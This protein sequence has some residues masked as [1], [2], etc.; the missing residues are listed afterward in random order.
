MLDIV[1]TIITETHSSDYQSGCDARFKKINDQWG[2]KFFE[3]EKIRDQ[4]FDLQYTAWEIGCGPELGDKFDLT[5]PDGTPVYGYITEC[6]V[7]DGNVLYAEEMGDESTY[8]PDLED[9][10]SDDM[11][12]VYGYTRMIER[13]KRVMEVEDI[14]GGNVGILD[15]GRLVVIDFSGCDKRNKFIL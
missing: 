2:L 11:H 15:S 6:I 5:L 3:E 13:L 8:N 10:E 7:K 12:Q 14:H 4:T 9:V 1:E